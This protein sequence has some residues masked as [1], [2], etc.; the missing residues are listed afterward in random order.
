MGAK[1]PRR[2]WQNSLCDTFSDAFNTLCLSWRAVLQYSVT[3]D[4]KLINHMTPKTK[5]ASLI[6]KQ[7]SSSTEKEFKAMP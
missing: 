7:Q 2:Q 5:I 6:W 1:E 4:E 3:G